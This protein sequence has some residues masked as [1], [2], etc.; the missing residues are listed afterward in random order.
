M[1]AERATTAS[2]RKRARFQP[3]AA[4]VLRR[5]RGE[6][7]AQGYISNEI[8]LPLS[9]SLTAANQHRSR[10]L[11]LV[12]QSRCGSCDCCLRQAACFQF[13][14]LFHLILLALSPISFATELLHMLLAAANAFARLRYFGS[15]HSRQ[16]EEFKVG[17]ALLPCAQ[18]RTLTQAHIHAQASRSVHDLESEI[19][20]EPTSATPTKP[21]IEFFSG[22]AVRGEI[23]RPKLG[24]I[25]GAL[26]ETSCVCVCVCAPKKNA[27]RLHCCRLICGSQ[28]VAANN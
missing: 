25:A 15:Q 10:S 2:A 4:R 3:L 7:D 14:R 12:R 13:V 1:S 6:G 28:T 8:R 11:D 18:R 21:S 16:I 9:L 22:I 24:L 19:N 27:T 26:K 20:S 23:K 5:A 17:C